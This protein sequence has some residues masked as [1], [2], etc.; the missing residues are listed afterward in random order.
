MSIQSTKIAYCSL[1]LFS[2]GFFFPITTFAQTS[3]RS[4]SAPTFPQCSAKLSASGDRKHETEGTHKV[5][6]KSDIEGT[7]DIYTLPDGNF[8]ECSCP[9]SGETGVQINWW[10]INGLPLGRVDIDAYTRNGWLL[11]NGA[12]W[13]LLDGQYLVTTEEFSCKNRGIQTSA[14]K[15]PTP[16]PRVTKDPLNSPTPIL[17]ESTD[18]DLPETGIPLFVTVGIL[19]SAIVG[20]YL[21]SYFSIR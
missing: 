1:L 2:C 10:Y 20:F 19:G 4:V 8:V 3:G 18:K 13:D 14:T 21:R 9:T 15:T 17:E 16:T 6:G 12:N 11:E 7:R 5:P